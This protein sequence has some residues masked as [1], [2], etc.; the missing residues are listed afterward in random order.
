MI[1]ERFN[2][3]WVVLNDGKNPFLVILIEA[4][5]RCR[6]KVSPAVAHKRTFLSVRADREDDRRLRGFDEHLNVH[7]ELHATPKATCVC[8][9]AEHQE[10][11]TSRQED[12]Q[13][14]QVGLDVVLV[15]ADLVEPE[16]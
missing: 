16:L 6:V 10:E 12:R 3:A 9:A 11:V 13:A 15:N 8:R 1:I 5:A 2:A 14:L 4:V 7:E